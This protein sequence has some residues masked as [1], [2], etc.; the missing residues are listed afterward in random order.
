MDNLL[1]KAKYH[2]LTELTSILNTQLK[3]LPD[4]RGSQQLSE[5]AVRMRYWDIW[6]INEDPSH[7]ISKLKSAMR[8]LK[9]VRDHEFM[10]EGP[11]CTMG[12]ECTLV[13]AAKKLFNEPE[14]IGRDRHALL[15]SIHTYME[16]VEMVFDDPYL[17]GETV[18][19]VKEYE[20]TI[21]GQENMLRD[22]KRI[23]AMST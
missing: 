3:E 15:A 10:P 6:V 18:Q 23:L 8:V 21:N 5:R 2:E 17:F 11:E 14:V 7:R 4:G 12:R 1:K 9:L 20:I 22:F 16:L 19:L 13:A